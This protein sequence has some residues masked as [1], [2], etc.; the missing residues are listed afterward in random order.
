MQKHRLSEFIKTTAGELGFSFCGIAKSESLD[1]E[2]KN[3]E[4]WLKQGYHGEM[5]YMENYFDMRINPSKLVPGAKSVISL[6][7]NYFPPEKQAKDKPQISKYAYG[8]DYHYVIKKKLKVFI[9][10]LKAKTGD[11]NGR[12]FVDSAP[13][14][15]RAWAKKSGLGWIGKN[16][17]L[18]NKGSGSFFFLAQIISD[19]EPEYDNPLNKDYCGSCTACIDACPTGAI[20]Q[21]YNV[22]ANKCISYL[23]IELKNEIPIEFS[24]KMENWLFGCDICQDVCPWNRFSKKHNHP[25]IAPN[26][27]LLDMKES[28][29]LEITK[30]VFQKKFPKTPLKR[31]GLERIKQNIIFLSEKK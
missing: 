27:A 21:P 7:F 15:E 23:T 9:D 13:V 2:A 25:E 29:W 30:S 3:L 22:D 5:S 17:L 8:R 11:F 10:T 18:I 6:L 4:N 16:T 19:L 28:D 14:L 24:G 20:N 12:A 1:E 31:T 26:K